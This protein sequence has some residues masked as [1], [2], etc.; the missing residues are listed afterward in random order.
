MALHNAA[1]FRRLVALTVGMG[2][3]LA[4]GAC[5]NPNDTSTNGDKQTTTSAKSSDHGEVAIFTPSDVLTISQQTPLNT[6]NAFTSDLT[7]ALKDKDVKQRDVTTHTSDTLEK[8]SQA[9]QDYVVKRISDDKADAGDVTL[10]VAP[11]Y[12]SDDA[13]QQ[14]GDYVSRHIDWSDDE[15][16]AADSSDNTNDDGDADDINANDVESDAAKYISAA[17]RLVSALNLAQN[18]GMHVVLMSNTIDGFT[19]DALVQASTAEQIGN[20]QA[21]QL[22]NKL[23]LDKASSDNPKSIEVLL[24]YSD[25]GATDMDSDAFAQ[26]VFRGI[27]KV[28]QPYFA[29][30]KAYSPSGLLDA[31]STNDDWRSVLFDAADSTAVT[32]ELATRLCTEED[33]KDRTTIDGIIAVNDHVASSVIDGLHDMGY[34]GSSA[35]INPSITISGIVDNITGKPDLNRT[36]VPDPIKAPENSTDD[37]T[38]S[39]QSADTDSGEYNGANDQWPIVTGYGA[40]IDSMPEI[41][42]GHLWMTALEDRKQLAADTAKVCVSLN[43]GIALTSLSFITKTTVN[44][45]KDVAL[46]SETPLTVSASNLKAD[47]IEP[48]YISLADAGL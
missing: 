43:D 45:V 10:V 28:L 22:V 42:N 47:L 48:G 36:A 27:W 9:V 34:V 46:V 18:S 40:Y 33:S 14:Y 37:S 21:K 23:A 20:L 7:A 11:V 31:N 6:W 35:D 3:V 1:T 25:A 19:P 17:S 16:A 44:G 41:V 2:L 26:D 38:N 24:P 5:R 13:A 30:G 32:Q 29:E 12:E 4:S 39:D 15:N 8:Q